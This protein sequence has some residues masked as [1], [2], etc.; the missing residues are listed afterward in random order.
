[1]DYADT[2]IQMSQELRQVYKLANEGE[3]NQAL[4]KAVDVRQLASD[5]VYKLSEIKKS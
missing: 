5:L 1:M 3:I 4:E 2:Y